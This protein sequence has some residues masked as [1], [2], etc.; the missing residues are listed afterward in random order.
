[1]SDLVLG[2]QDPV[3]N[4][5]PEIRSQAAA[6]QRRAAASLRAG[7]PGYAVTPGAAAA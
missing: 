7:G 1:M 3:I 4:M 5:D 2:G 6:Q